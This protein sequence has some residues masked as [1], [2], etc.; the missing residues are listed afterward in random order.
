MKRRTALAKKSA[1]GPRTPHVQFKS[2]R[3]AANYPCARHP[4]EDP[5]RVHRASTWHHWLP[6][7]KLRE[8]VRGLRL[9][10]DDAYKLLRKLIHDERNLTPYALGCHISAERDQPRFGTSAPPFRRSEVPASA[11]EFARE[12]GLDWWL[13][14]TYK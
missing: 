2:R 6:K 11:F 7:Y 5:R 13:D 10:Y 1:D 14:R 4:G 12:I 3:A 8:Y 9:P